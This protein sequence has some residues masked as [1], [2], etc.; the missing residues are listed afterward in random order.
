M[1]EERI[2][3]RQKDNE[4]LTRTGADTQ[5]GQLLRRYW[6]PIALSRQLHPGDKPEALIILG[7]ELV[8]FRDDAGHPGLLGRKCAHRRADLSVGRVEHGGIRCLYHGWLYDING[9]CLQQPAESSTTQTCADIK[10]LSYPCHE[11]GGAIWA[12]FG[13]GEAPLFPHYPPLTAPGTHVFAQ[14]WYTKC[15]YLQ[16]NEG[17]LD[18]S[19]TSYLHGTVKKGERAPWDVAFEGFQVDTAPDL[20]I[21]DTRFGVRIFAERDTLEN[22]KKMLRVTNFIMPNAAAANGFETGFGRGGCA[23]VWHVPIDDVQH[24]RFEITFHC[25]VSMD[26]GLA[27]I[28]HLFEDEF[29]EDGLSK[30]RTEN[31]FIQDRKEMESTT[32]SGVG[33][34]F[35]VHDIFIVEGQGKIH[36]RSQENLA[37]SDIAIVRARMQLR[38]GLQSIKN[39]EDPRGVV[40]REDERVFS[41]FLVLTEI[42]DEEADSKAFCHELEQE[43]IYRIDSVS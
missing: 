5:M 14:R 38:E 41:D 36:D 20:S 29:T 13:P 27:D 16:G 9:N 40:R 24:Y 18:P 6:Q 32:F 28:E 12:Y 8:L 4:L 1:T 39:G 31:G 19:H 23:M 43:D 10:Q 11:A 26:D 25:K 37:H 30:R 35:P 33:H 22:N 15:N 34:C 21:E 2:E 7:E 42:L 17:N 3:L